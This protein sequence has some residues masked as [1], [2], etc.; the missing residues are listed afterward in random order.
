MTAK[1]AQLDFYGTGLVVPGSVSLILALQW[2]GSVF[3]WNDRKII[4]LLVLSVT[5]FVGFILVQTFLP[6]TATIPPRIFKQR[7]ILAGFLSTICAI[8]GVS[9]VES[10]IRFLPLVLSMV[11]AMLTAG[12]LIRRIGY[13]TPVMIF[14]LCLMAIGAGLMY[15]LQVDTGSPQWIGYQIIYGIGAGSATQ[16]PNIAAQT[17]LPKP[18][19]PVGV[20]LMYFGNFM[21]SAILLSVAQNILNSQLLY[22][23]SA[24]PSINPETVLNNGVTSLTDLPTS[25]R[26]TVLVAYNEAIRHVFLVALILVCMSMLGALSLEWRSTKEAHGQEKVHTKTAA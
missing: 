3:A 11:V 19:V 17:V 14:G 21:G 4:A 16:V 5:L 6:K 24:I 26:M 25:I 1:L 7:S 12:A 15:T 23:L 8:Q 9:A 18:D 13:Y 22:R 10:G 2:G 20:S